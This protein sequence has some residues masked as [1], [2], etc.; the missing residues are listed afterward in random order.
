M[1]RCLK[2]SVHVTCILYENTSDCFIPDCSIRVYYVLLQ[3]TSQSGNVR[4]IFP[5]CLSDHDQLK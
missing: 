2:T 5:F 1:L 3:V 4:H